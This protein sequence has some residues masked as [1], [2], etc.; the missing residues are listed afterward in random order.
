MKRPKKITVKPFLND[1]LKPEGT[2][3]VDGKELPLYRLYYIISYNR[4][5]MTVRSRYGMYYY[6]GE[7]ESG[8]VRQV[9]DFET[10][11]FE[12]II[13]FEAHPETQEYELKGL[14]ARFDIY[15]H[16]V[17]RVLSNYVIRFLWLSI[18]HTKSEFINTLNLD[19]DNQDAMLMV[20][21]ARRLFPNLHE[22][23]LPEFETSV[24]ALETYDHLYPLPSFFHSSPTVIDWV[25]GSH[26]MEVEAKLEPM[27]PKTREQVL[28]TINHIMNQ[29][30]QQL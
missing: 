16:T 13:R 24:K 5:N 18:N 14:P 8:K 1:R 10:R 17:R 12:Q 25:N 3:H 19:Q 7:I 6:K 11:V 29:H 2:A 21:A 28:T 23:A 30:M 26:R 9:I 15:S 27:N 4:K 22:V 20:K